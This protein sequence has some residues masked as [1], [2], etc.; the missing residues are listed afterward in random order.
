MKS[1]Y[2]APL[3]GG[4]RPKS[5]VQR[6]GLNVLMTEKTVIRQVFVQPMGR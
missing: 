3:T 6:H 4:S 1:L 5:E 2:K